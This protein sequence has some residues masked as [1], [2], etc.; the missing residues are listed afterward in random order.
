METYTHNLKIILVDSDGNNVSGNDFL[1]EI[2]HALCQSNTK[3]TQWNGRNID[4]RIQ[5]HIKEL[6]HIQKQ[7][8]G[9]LF[10]NSIYDSDSI[11]VNHTNQIITSINNEQDCVIKFHISRVI[12]DKTICKDSCG[13]AY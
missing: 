13:V 8:M 6:N 11:I 9:D 4:V 1:D 7:F 2:K 3:K 5:W 10:T 12:G